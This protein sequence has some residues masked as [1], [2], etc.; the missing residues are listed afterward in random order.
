HHR[1][2]QAHD[3]LGARLG[4]GAG[5]KQRHDRR[6][7]DEDHDDPGDDAERDRDRAE[8]DELA[9]MPLEAGEEMPDLEALTLAHRVA[10]EHETAQDHGEEQADRERAYE[11]YEVGRYLD[12]HDEQEHADERPAL[13]AH[14]RPRVGDPAPAVAGG[15]AAALGNERAIGQRRRRVFHAAARRGVGVL[16]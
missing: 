8:P 9:G 5:A 4:A 12:D 10:T 13:V 16:G 1:Q 14:E 3:L 11:R 15:H 2:H 7:Y 6:A